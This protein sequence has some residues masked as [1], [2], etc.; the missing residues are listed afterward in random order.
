MKLAEY[1]RS[2]DDEAL[3]S[4]IRKA[5]DERNLRR[6]MKATR[7]KSE[8]E[9]GSL[10]TLG[11]IKPKYM[12]GATV[13]ITEL[14]GTRAVVNIIQGRAF[15][16]RATKGITIPYSCLRPIQAPDSLEDLD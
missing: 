5:V 6:Q 2:C 11:D 12:T 3:E 8:L 4:L 13:E 9:V 15:R 10:A 16:G 1:I 14:K 7:I